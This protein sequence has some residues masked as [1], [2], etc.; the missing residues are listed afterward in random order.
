MSADDI[1]RN[2]R[3]SNEQRQIRKG[4]LTGEFGNGRDFAID[5]YCGQKLGLDQ[6]QQDRIYPGSKG[7]RYRYNNLVP[8][9]GS[10]NK[11]RGDKDFFEFFKRTATK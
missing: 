4:K 10:C 5:I 6:I 11:A 3:G 2:D 7:G 9:C 1:E 8:C